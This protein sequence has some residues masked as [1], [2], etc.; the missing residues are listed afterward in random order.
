MVNYCRDNLVKIIGDGVDLLFCNETEALDFTGAEDLDSAV[1]ALKKISQQFALTLG[2]KGAL[3]FDGE[4]LQ[5]IAPHNVEPKDSNGA[6]DL[7]AGAFLYAISHGYDFA[8]AG[9]LA[10]LASAQLVTQFGPRL[11]PSQY[12]PLREQ[13]LGH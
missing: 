2:A 12:E 1:E 5:K 7:F 10:S 13:A 11:D 8:Q 4:R 3:V 9:K 6:G